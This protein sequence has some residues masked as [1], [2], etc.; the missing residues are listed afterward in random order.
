M[1]IS[2]NDL[3]G[4]KGWLGLW[5]LLMMQTNLAL[6]MSTSKFSSCCLEQFVLVISNFHAKLQIGSFYVLTKSFESLEIDITALLRFLHVIMSIRRFPS[7]KHHP[8]LSNNT[9]HGSCWGEFSHRNKRR[10]RSR[11]QTR[12]SNQI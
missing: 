4:S 6:F 11:R 5:M 8:A 7:S 3:P 10:K 9:S 1:L 12:I 2:F